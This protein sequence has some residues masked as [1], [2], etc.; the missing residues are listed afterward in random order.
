MTIFVGKSWIFPKWSFFDAF[1]FSQDSG[2]F[3]TLFW[4]LYPSRLI[5][6]RSLPFPSDFIEIWGKSMIY[7]FFLEFNS[8]KK[9]MIFV[10]KSWILPERSFF[11]AFGFSRDLGLFPT[12]FW[13]RSPSRL[14][15]NRYLPFAKCINTLTLS[16]LLLF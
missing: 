2:L 7:R 6:N 12:L 9:L 4:A 1:G 10:G 14:F 8:I 13:I 16:V 3:P 5:P 11:A 15:P